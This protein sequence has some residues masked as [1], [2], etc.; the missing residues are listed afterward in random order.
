[1]HAGGCSQS[2]LKYPQGESKAR[3]R[4][5]WVFSTT[6]SSYWVVGFQKMV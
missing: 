4:S 5:F 1:M 3:Q 2:P 6:C